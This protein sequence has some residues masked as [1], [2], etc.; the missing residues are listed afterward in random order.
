MTK[1]GDL[2]PIMHPTW[3][4]SLPWQIRSPVSSLLLLAQGRRKQFLTGPA[5]TRFVII[6]YVHGASTH[7]VCKAH[8]HAK[9]ANSRG[10]WGH[11]PQKNFKNYTL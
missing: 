10:V 8:V 7:I 4:A 9:H 2:V 3:K 5:A 1:N 11:A 6:V